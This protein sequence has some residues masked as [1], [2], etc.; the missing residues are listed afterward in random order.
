[1]V[2]QAINAGIPAAG[3]DTTVI[4]DYLEG[5]VRDKIT[6]DAWGKECCISEAFK[7]EGRA[8]IARAV[9][10]KVKLTT[11]SDEKCVEALCKRIADA[12]KNG[13]PPVGEI[14]NVEHPELPTTDRPTIG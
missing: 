2:A 1:M 7:V 12:T 9:Q 8:A 13:N 4:V 11:L 3:A 5:F 6:V 14:A 10:W